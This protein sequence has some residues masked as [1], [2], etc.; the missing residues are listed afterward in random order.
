[1]IP[2]KRIIIEI[3]TL[4]DE[5]WRLLFRFINKCCG[6]G[7][8]TT[9]DYGVLADKSKICFHDFN[10][11]N[12]KDDAIYA[13][14]EFLSFDDFIKEVENG[15]VFT[16]TILYIKQEDSSDFNLL[17]PYF[18]W[19]EQTIHKDVEVSFGIDVTLL[20]NKDEYIQKFG[21]ILTFINL[22]TP[23]VGKRSFY[24]INWCKNNN[25]RKIAYNFPYK[26]NDSSQIKPES[27]RKFLA[28]LKIVP[29][30][31]P[32]FSGSWSGDTEES[33][34][35]TET[36]N[37]VKA[38]IDKL[39]ERLTYILPLKADKFY[40]LFEE[41]FI[42]AYLFSYVENDQNPESIELDYYALKTTLHEY[43]INIYE[44]VQNI[45][46]HTEEKR[47]LLS[48]VFNKKRNLSPLLHD[49]IPDFSS[50]EDEDRFVEIALYDFGETGI[51]ERFGAE[52]LTLDTFF[53][54]QV[55]LPT[56][57]D[58]PDY[59]SL[60]YSAHLGIKTFVSSVMKYKGYFCA[61]S[62]IHN[63]MKARI[64]SKGDTLAY[65]ENISYLS[66]TH[67]K[68]VLPVKESKS[69]YSFEPIQS[70]SIIG[71]LKD[72]NTPVFS[73]QCISQK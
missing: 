15:T 14:G 59:L 52:G 9:E 55:F 20:S 28:I 31:L 67:Y 54:P 53:N 60:R 73:Y 45:I 65:Q 23:S 7:I 69:L 66:G 71:I 68:I 27:S 30:V 41:W 21:Q 37:W 38:S 49:M 32:L 47:G 5:K 50:Y 63:K 44:L 24:Y 4:N 57:D 1:M 8:F 16:C 12:D 72:Y 19:L 62:N 70:S 39:N 18:I 2:T 64:E 33:H 43:S 61:E 26:S 11:Y 29:E 22:P 17:M 51:V 48:I 58:E 40:S 46:F 34:L 35:G 42:K 6:R 36:L 3:S 25:L 10:N 13:Y 56:D